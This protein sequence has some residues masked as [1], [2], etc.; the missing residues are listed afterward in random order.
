[1]RKSHTKFA[2]VSSFLMWPA[3]ILFV[4]ITFLS[5]CND[6]EEPAPTMD[7]FEI[8]E[9]QEGLD[10]LNALLALEDA[11]GEPLFASVHIALKDDNITFFAPNNEAFANLVD[12]I[13]VSSSTQLRFDI[14]RDFLLYHIVDAE[15]A[16]RAG[17]LPE[18]VN[19]YLN[20]ETISV[21]KGADPIA[22]NES[23]QPGLTPTIVSTD[24]RATN[25]IVQIVDE[26][27]LP[28]SITDEIAP[29]FGTLGGYI[30]MVGRYT[31][32]DELLRAVD[33]WQTI[34]NPDETFTLL[35]IENGALGNFDP[36][37]NLETA[38]ALASYHTLSGLPFDANIFPSSVTTLLQ[39]DMIYTSSVDTDVVQGNFSAFLVKLQEFSNGH[40]YTTIVQNNTGGFSPSFLRYSALRPNGAEYINQFDDLTLLAAAVEKVPD[41]KSVLEG[42]APYTLLS[43]N[44]DAFA[45]SG[46]T[47]E[48][49]DTMQVAT[50]QALLENHII[51]G[52]LL[53]INELVGET[54]GN[55][56]FT[57][58]TAPHIIVTDN[59]TNMSAETVFE[60]ILLDAGIAHDI[61]SVLV[62]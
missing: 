53:P 22:L 61:D 31:D 39:G 47:S 4:A 17:A 34:A 20:A 45:A 41:V 48:G 10:S 30:S 37:A 29:A 11:S 8:L 18:S 25:G 5:S 24:M 14:I 42:S 21:N 9:S 3:A 32:M 38:T 59:N 15:Q 26:V 13:G 55:L 16:Y 57:E 54:K 40:L 52:E 12:A 7:V 27:L 51:Q 49:I 35:A 6:D 60:N 62:P 33:L 19:T 50:L 56:S 1:M 44:D 2:G 23:T 43:P 36:S 58:G 46:I 28:S